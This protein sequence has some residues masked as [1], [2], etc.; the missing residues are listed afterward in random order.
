MVPW[1]MIPKI[2]VMNYES[3][4]LSIF[5]VQGLMNREQFYLSTVYYYFVIYKVQINMIYKNNITF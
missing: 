4:C 5:I 1:D 2:S 3:V